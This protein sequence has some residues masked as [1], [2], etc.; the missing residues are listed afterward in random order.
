MKILIYLIIKCM[1][2]KDYDIVLI[3]QINSCFFDTFC[4]VFVRVDLIK[5]IFSQSDWCFIIWTSQFARCFNYSSNSFSS[6][7]SRIHLFVTISMSIR[8]FSKFS[9]LFFVSKS[10]LS[11]INWDFIWLII[12]DRSMMKWWQFNNKCFEIWLK[13]QLSLHFFVS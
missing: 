13:L 2:F 6:E 5:Q 9:M 12:F 10:V 4:S 8:N 7:S 11:V 3:I 1:Q